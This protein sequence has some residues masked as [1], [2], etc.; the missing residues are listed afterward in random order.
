M[1]LE[2]EINYNITKGQLFSMAMLI[3]KALVKSLA[4]LITGDTEL[5]QSVIDDNEKIKA[6]EIKVNESSLSTL[7]FDQTPSRM[8]GSVLSLQKLNHLLESIGNH[9]A[10]IAVS[11]G[12][13]CSVK[14]HDEYNELARMAEYCLMVYNEAI[15][16]FFEMNTHLPDEQSLLTKKILHLKTML[17]HKTV[18]KMFFGLIYFQDALEV[19]NICKSIE[20]ISELSRQI[21]YQTGSFFKINKIILPRAQSSAI[22]ELK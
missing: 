18:E 11:T 19:V 17:L 4:S 6:F 14:V 12:K 8:I 1:N 13:F 3:Q 7:L 22:R 10:H 21:D 16:H 5:A 15:N 9:V 2:I 20:S